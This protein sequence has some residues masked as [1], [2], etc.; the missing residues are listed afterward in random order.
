LKLSKEIISY[1]LFGV[2][3]TLVNIVSYGILTKLGDVDYKI[4][5]TVAWIISVLFAF[6]TNK[7]YVFNSKTMELKALWKEFS[8]FVLFRL[9]SYI[10]DIGVMII[11]I[12]WLII[13]DL[14]SK[15]IANFIVV[16]LNYFASKLIIFKRAK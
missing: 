5:T 12:E 6:V 15:V 2:L 3:T 14:I 13:N 11:M 4:A 8:S 9:L 1:L 10:V 16:I 7:L